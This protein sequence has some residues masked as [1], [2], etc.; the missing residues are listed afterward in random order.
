MTRDG[1]VVRFLAYTGVRYGEMAALAVAD[2][3]MQCRRVQVGCSV[4]EVKGK[5]VWSTPKNHE[6]RSV[7]FPRFL[8]ETSLGGWSGGD[9]T[10]LCSPRLAAA[11]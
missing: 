6:R 1:L 11:C 9:V 10:S 8:T 7:P 4:T 5:L 2:F 3:D